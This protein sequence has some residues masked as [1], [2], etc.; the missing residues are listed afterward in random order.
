ML[1][2][3]SIS[4]TLVVVQCLQL[5]QV[6]QV[7]SAPARAPMAAAEEETP[8][9]TWSSKG[10]VGGLMVLKQ[11]RD[12][13]LNNNLHDP[14]VDYSGYAG[15]KITDCSANN[16]RFR[17]ADGT[18]TDLTRPLAGAAGVAFGRNVPPSFIDQNAAANLMTPNPSEV[19]KK[20]FTRGEFKPVPFLNM[21]AASWIQFMN[22]DWLTHGRN[23]DK[24]AYQVPGAGDA[25]LVERTKENTADSTQYK[26]EFGKTTLNDVTHWWDGSQIYGSNLREQLSVRAMSEGKMKTVVQN[27]RELLP[28]D[29][30]LNAANN[31]QNRGHEVTGFRDNWWVGLSMLHHLFVK[32]HNAIAEMLWK[33]HVT[34]LGNGKYQWKNGSQ[35]LVLSA[36]GID[37]QVF[38]VAR[39]INAAVMAKIH[40]VEW[41]PAILANDTLKRAMYANWYGLI[42]PNSW[43]KALRRIPYLN[44]ADWIRGTS[45][46]YLIGGVVGDKRND[47]GVPF[48]ITEEFTSVYRLHSLLPEALEFKH[49]GKPDSIE[50]VAFLDT[51][52]DKSYGIMASHDLKDL[53]YSFGTQHPGQLVLNN[54]PKF[55]QELPIPGHGI[56]DLGMVDIM[57]DRERGVPR[58]NQF[59][60]G[61]NLKPITKYA[62]FF[63]GG[64]AADARQEAIL[65]KFYEVYGKDENGNDNV[66]MIDLLVGTL[67]EEVR[68]QNFGFGETMFQIFIVMASRRLMADRFYTDNYRP[69]YYT[70]SGIEW[71]DAEGF[72]ERVIVRHMPELKKHV[73]GLETAFNPWKP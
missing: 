47:Y 45:S 10:T 43:T 34:A 19:S 46:G 57:R 58:Y 20:F 51:R 64:K 67:S 53:F 3:P 8:W 69:E 40:T 62:D 63:P 35:K 68:P 56:M 61:I 14:H 44:R 41:T 29:Q 33:K 1:K 25:S 38:Q 28:Y 32:E 73:Q 30:E 48:S 31:K 66:E 26:R 11:I 17:S 36:R 55:M 16:P 13:L 24:N 72:L 4:L 23:M 37:E 6:G 9:T 21:L 71:I 60:R 42:N 12:G 65:A 27:G 54:F 5:A 7:W 49:A 59:R 18:C 2:K 15:Y 52:N 70:E 39:L 22:H 50:K